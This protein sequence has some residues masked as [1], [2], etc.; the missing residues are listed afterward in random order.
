MAEP[1]A[2]APS[3]NLDNTALR[4]FSPRPRTHLKIGTRQ[5]Q[6]QPSGVAV[7]TTANN[8]RGASSS[9][10]TAHTRCAAVCSSASSMPTDSDTPDRTQQRHIERQGQYLGAWGAVKEQGKREKMPDIIR[11]IPVEAFLPFFTLSLEA[12]AKV[13]RKLQSNMVVIS[14]D[15]TVQSIMTTLEYCAGNRVHGPNKDKMCFNS[16]SSFVLTAV[17][18]WR[19]NSV[20][21][22]A[23]DHHPAVYSGR[24]GTMPQSN[25]H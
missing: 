7:P 9:E 24:T 6:D 15:G 4:S 17:Y 18:S 3:R 1:K 8:K 10:V 11:R 25:Q 2:L 21:S 12:A 13:R 23:T 16:A 22:T 19:L 20:I 5:R 14:T